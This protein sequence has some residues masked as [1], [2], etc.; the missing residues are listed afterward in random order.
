MKLTDIKLT[1][2]YLKLNDI[3]Y[4]KVNPTPLSDAKLI[5]FNQKALEL[6]NI[7]EKEFDQ[8]ELVKLING[9]KLFDGSTPYAM[10]YAGHQFGHFVPRLGD[11]RA[12]NFGSYNGIN[13][14]TKGSGETLYSRNGDGRAVLRSSIR[15]YLLSELMHSL[16]IPSSRS[17][18][19]VGSSTDVYRESVESGAIVM[20]LSSS[21]VRFGTFEYFYYSH[22]YEKLETLA[23]YVIEESYAHLKDV[24]DRYFLMYEALVEKTAHLMAFWQSV[25][26][27]HGVMNT[28]NM[29]IEALTIDYGPFAFLDDYEF[30]YI[31]NHTDVEGRYSFSNQPPVARW[32][33]SMLAI[34]LSPIVNFDKMKN[35]YEKFSSIFASKFMELMLK[36]LGLEKEEEGDTKLIN[37]LFTSLQDS[38]VDYTL[39]FRRLSRFD[40]DTKILEDICVNPE[41]IKLWI[42]DYKER[43]DKNS[44]SSDQRANR[45]LKINPKYVLKNYILQEAIDS[46]QD[47]DFSLVNELLNIAQNP[48]DEHVAFEKYSKATPNIFKNKKL[49]CSS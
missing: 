42:R 44:I 35:S 46:A 19:L 25:G 23:D 10:C 16:G 2:P 8:D 48:Y 17:L 7:D 30:N 38:G 21:W 12:I 4:H 9:E 13:L 18:A 20:R 5:S 26:F 31:C 29:S 6:L 45:M 22:Q 43:L 11:G 41:G 28:D 15:E 33:L 40:D 3:F 47:G 1:T 14:Q 24:D 34:A 27:N 39:F 49:S 37:S 36:K 32:N